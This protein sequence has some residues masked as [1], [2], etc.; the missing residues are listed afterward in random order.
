VVNGQIFTISLNRSPEAP[1]KAS[2]L[3]RSPLALMP[4]VSQ[5]RAFS[6]S[7]RLSLVN[8]LT[9]QLVNLYSLSTCQPV[10]KPLPHLYS[11]LTKWLIASLYQ[12]C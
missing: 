4:G 3:L 10:N 5:L 11:I 2:A 1:L 7:L 8:K 6:A 9:R 12:L